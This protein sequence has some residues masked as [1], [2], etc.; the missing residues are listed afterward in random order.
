M[1]AGTDVG[2]PHRTQAAIGYVAQDE[3]HGETACGPSQPACDFTPR[4]TCVHIHQIAS[5]SIDLHSHIAAA[6]NWNSQG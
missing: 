6:V 4:A 3:A 2:P 1:P 5:C